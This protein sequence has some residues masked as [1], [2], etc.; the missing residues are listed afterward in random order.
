VAREF[1]VYYNM[2]KHKPGKSK[3]TNK[4]VATD[5]GTEVSVIVHVNKANYVPNWIS[6]RK[7]I[8]DLIFTADVKKRDLEKLEADEQVIS[9]SINEQ[10]G[11][12]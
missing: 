10:L 1:F 4:G 12:N 3:V 7:K 8:T 9:V 2:E 5:A 11:S 6:L